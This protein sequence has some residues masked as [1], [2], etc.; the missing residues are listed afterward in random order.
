MMLQ[1]VTKPAHSSTPPASLFPIFTMSNSYGNKLHF[2][3]KQ[4]AFL[5]GLGAH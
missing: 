4:K 1:L 5:K 2:F 3:P